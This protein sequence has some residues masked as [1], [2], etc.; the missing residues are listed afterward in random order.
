MIV[1]VPKLSVRAYFGVV[2]LVLILALSVL[3]LLAPPDGV[4]RAPLL[5]FVGRF[6]PLS[7]HLPIAVLFLVALF[8]LA[9]RSRHFSYLLTSVEFL[10]CVAICGAIL[11]AFLGWCLAR[12]GGASGQ[13]MTQHMWGG[14]VVATATW[15]CWFLRARI[16]LPRFARFYGCTLIA[17]LGLVSFTGYRGGQL[18]QG[19]DHLT[20]F[21]PAPLRSLLG[22]AV[23]ENGTPDSP[24]ADASTFY[25]AR[26]QPLFAG[27]CVTCHGGKKHKAGL[28]LDS[29]AAVMR[30]GKHGPVVR[31]GDAKSSE[32]FRRITLPPMDDDFMPAEHKRPLSP[33]DIKLIELWISNGASDTQS[34]EAIKTVPLVATGQASVAEIEFEEI[35]PAAVARERSVLA[36]IVSK[37]QQRLPNI[38]DYRSRTSAD[39]VIAASWRGPQFGDAELGALAPLRDRIVA[40]D[41]SNTAI[42]DRS[43]TVLAD[44]KNLRQLRLTNTNITDATIEELGSLRELESLSIFGTRVTPSA[45]PVIAQLPKLRHIYAGATRI[46]AAA[47]VPVSLQGKLVF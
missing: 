17:A 23:S 16:N 36:P 25:G 10:F 33:D 19:A 6:H 38:V 2:T 8:E 42:T 9:G 4:E 20:E 45:L 21:M 7:V 24:R 29:F 39:V 47:E 22:F 44:M 41:F 46:S 14:I 5:Q 13:L 1:P 11:A 28:R 15:I 3:L 43:A 34:A 12:G 40:A 32:L 31:V 27:H 26:I 37:I 35:D 18:S 30:G